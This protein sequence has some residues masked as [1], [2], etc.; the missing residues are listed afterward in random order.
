MS[1]PTAVLFDWDNTLV[2][3]WGCIRQAMNETLVAMGRAPWDM[4]E[5]RR[6]VAHSMRDSFPQLFGERWSEARDIFYASFAAIHIELLEPLP[7]A[8]AMLKRLSGAGIP[9]GVISNK[10][11]KY[12]RQEAAHL[13]WNG[14]FRHLAGA[15]DSTADK[16]SPV[17]VQDALAIIGVARDNRVWFVGDAAI[18]MECAH[19]AGVTPFLVKHD[20]GFAGEFDTHR[21]ARQFQ[22]WDAFDA[23]LDEISVP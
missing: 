21:P 17:P 14:Y 10:T 12:I 16:P 20:E 18:D 22:S 3:S 5:T 19:N 2:D 1:R 9:L 8:A 23:Y 7:G 6:R 11:G 13:G 4:A 15:G